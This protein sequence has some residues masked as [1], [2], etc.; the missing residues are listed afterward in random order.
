[1]AINKRMLVL[2]KWLLLKL[3]TAE[4]GKTGSRFF[5]LQHHHT[6]LL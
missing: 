5:F 6:F 3:M 1:M 2:L 4:E